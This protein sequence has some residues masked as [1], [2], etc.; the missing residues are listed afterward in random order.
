MHGLGLGLNRDQNGLVTD[1]EIWG[2]D[3]IQWSFHS[4]STCMVL[5]LDST[6]TRMVSWLILKSE[7]K[8]TYNEVSIHLAHA[9]SWTQDQNSVVTGLE[10]WV[11]D[12]IQWS[13]NSFTTY[14][15]LDSIKTRIVSWLVLKPEFK[16]TNKEA[17]IHLAHEWSWNL[18]LN[19]DQN[20]LVTGLE[21][22]GQ[23]HIQQI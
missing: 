22:R 16:T 8:T 19:Q 20:G 2:Q 18:G 10:A 14:M 6:E 11:Q 7:V 15:V 12:H 3:H 13:L 4:F 23:D 5:D 9:W 17:S 1:L 21:V